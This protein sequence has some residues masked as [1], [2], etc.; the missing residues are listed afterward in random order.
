MVPL[1]T[2]GHTPATITMPM[3]STAFIAGASNTNVLD[4]YTSAVTT[5]PTNNWWW[6]IFIDGTQA[7]VNGVGYHVQIKMTVDFLERQNVVG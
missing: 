3:V 4:F 7:L 2:S 5:T 1:S 6:G